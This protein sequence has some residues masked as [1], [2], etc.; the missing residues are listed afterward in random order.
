MGF[1]VNI[2]N[3]EGPLDLMLHLI[4]ENKLNLE[5]LNMD[6]L[7]DQYL[8]FLNAMESL[9]L[10]VASEFL[11]ELAGLI[12]YKSKKMLPREK[13]LI[14]ENYEEDQ[15]DKLVQRLY[16]YQRYKEVTK[17]FSDKYDE[18]QLLMEKPISDETKKWVQIIEEDDFEG[19]PYDIIKAMQK[20]MRR[21]QLNRPK[22]T[23]LTINEMSLDDRV[24]QI[25]SKLKNW[26]GKMNF[27]KLCEDCNTKHMYIVTFLSILNLVK[28]H[29]IN[30]YVDDNEDIWIVRG[31]SNE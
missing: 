28:Y 16:E 31:E 4:K 8:S 22:E 3:F 18:R 27:I 25:K 19:D 15:R 11:S 30:A 13:V 26:V 2:N 6:I 24:V 17:D 1:E 14:E 29:E 23:K 12:E 5:D 9:H 20:V 10:E 21:F 7:T